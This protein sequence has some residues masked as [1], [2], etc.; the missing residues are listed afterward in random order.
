MDS[1]G[2]FQLPPPSI[3]GDRTRSPCFFSAATAPKRTRFSLSELINGV[4]RP[5][6]SPNYRADGDGIGFLVDTRY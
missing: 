4:D 3:T 1:S 2:Q 6:V 5:A